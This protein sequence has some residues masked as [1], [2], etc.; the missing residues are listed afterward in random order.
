MAQA[1]APRLR[2]RERRDSA[3]ADLVAFM[4][5]ER[6]QHVNH[7]LVGV[8]VI[9][10]DEL[11]AA[12]HQPG[13]E[14]DVAGQPVKLGDHQHRPLAAAQIERGRQLR[15]IILPAALDFGELSQ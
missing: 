13:D 8:W 4:L 2:R 3:G 6:G 9:D 1:H 15:P 14:G 12:F 10:R 5:R 7:E 11:R